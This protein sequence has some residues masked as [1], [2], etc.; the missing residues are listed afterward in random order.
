M[1]IQ[2]YCDILNI[3]LSIKRFH[4]QNNRWIANFYSC[5]TMDGAALVSEYGNG[6]NPES[7]LKDY[8]NKI[9]GK[10]VVFYAMSEA[11]RREYVVPES[12]TYE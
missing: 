2:D 12:L 1:N 5:E 9:K 8:I 4:N 10:R 11:L 7:A 3:D 6:C